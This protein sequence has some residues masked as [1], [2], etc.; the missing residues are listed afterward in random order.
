MSSAGIAAGVGCAVGAAACFDGALAWQA[1]EARRVPPADRGLLRRLVRRPRWVAATGFAALGWPLQL[2]ALSLAPLTLVQPALAS[3]LVLLL[4]LG[5]IVLRERVGALEV[6][7]ALAVVA[8]VAILAWA[9]PDRRVAAAGAVSAVAC[10]GALA[11]V[12]ALP[13]ALRLP[14][15]LTAV[16]AGCAFAAT[17]LTSKLVS[18]ALARR[19][20]GPALAWAAATAAVVVLGVSADMTALQRLP[21]TRVA[22]A[23]LAIEVVL[24]VALAPL[25]AHE[26]WRG[27]PGGGAAIATG[28]AVL[29]AGTLPLASAP[30]VRALE[31]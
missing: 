29:L 19:D 17:G 16:A 4:V 31:T 22:P 6:A 23:I 15:R 3:G 9:A 11:A 28:L 8:G 26:A 30:A 14:A 24:P 18:D 25:L 5:A 12:A 2:A 13:L 1:L 21:A 27:T 10:V 20:A 7:G